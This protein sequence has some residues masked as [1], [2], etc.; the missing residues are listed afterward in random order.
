MKRFAIYTVICL[1]LL[2]SPALRAQGD[3]AATTPAATTPAA[4]D[5]PAPPAA[6]PDSSGPAAAE[7]APAPPS[8]PTSL[9]PDISVIGNVLG[10]L[11]THPASCND[12]IPE[13]QLNLSE[14]EVVV[15]SKIY[16]GISG[17]GVFTISP[18]SSGA[19]VGIEEGYISIEQLMNG[20]PIGA[21]LGVVRLPFGKMNPQHAHTL[22]YADTPSCVQNL[23]GDFR[24]NGGEFVAVL[25][26]PAG[27]FL[28]AQL[29]RWA[30][31]G[32]A[33]VDI[34]TPASIS[35]GETYGLAHPLTLGRLWASSS[36]GDNCEGELGASGAYGT[37]ET[38]LPI[39]GSNDIRILG[40]DSTWRFYFPHETRLM[41]Q[42]EAIQRTD[43]SLNTHG[44][45]VLG[46]LRP[47][48]FYE[49]GARYDWS[50]FDD[51]SGQHEKYAS[52]FAT[53]YLSEMT[54]V[55]LQV[56]SGINRDGQHEN[57]LIG[58]MVFGFGPHTHPLQ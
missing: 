57:E 1:F 53:R 26:A 34:D 30:S 41:L 12:G 47:G 20:V 52:V 21:R 29:G 55:R 3:T 7:P 28:Q 9:N 15:G 50:Q 4:S 17:L 43:P 46:T 27:I 58:Q 45:Y 33:P 32:D 35:S 16:P 18:T 8:A 2:A 14:L 22:P 39:S 6:A 5:T 51:T 10:G 36:L 44:Y 24:G 37:A 23:L 48:H 49:Y 40:M 56:K 25:P 19:S 11:A 31:V 38:V 54:F 42:A 13:K